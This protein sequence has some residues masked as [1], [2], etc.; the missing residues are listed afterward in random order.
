MKEKERR[1][2][3]ECGSQILQFRRLKHD[4]QVI[5]QNIDCG[6]IQRIPLTSLMNR[7]LLRTPAMWEKLEKRKKELDGKCGLC[8]ELMSVDSMGYQDMGHQIAFVENQYGYDA[9]AEEHDLLVYTDHGEELLVIDYL[10]IT[11]NYEGY[12]CIMINYPDAQSVQG[13][14]HIHLIKWKRA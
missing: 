4:L 5:C 7:T 2:C 1:T 13:H 8:E 14:T 9:V 12:D 3:I 6:R 11:K 10:E